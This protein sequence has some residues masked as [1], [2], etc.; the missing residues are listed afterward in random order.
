[1]MAETFSLTLRDWAS[2]PS[3]GPSIVV[4]HS[5]HCILAISNFRCLVNPQQ[6]IRS[7]YG[8]QWCTNPSK[9]S[10]GRSKNLAVGGGQH[11]AGYEC[12]TPPFEPHNCGRK[13]WTGA[14]AASSVRA[15]WAL[16]QASSVIDHA[17]V[18]P[19]RSTPK[20]WLPRREWRDRTPK[21]WLPRRE[22]RDRTGLSRS[23]FR[24]EM[25]TKHTEE[26]LL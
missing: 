2:A 23:V 20:T 4:P 5:N 26:R 11:P 8:G 18:H 19:K 13:A 17:E 14:S 16:A 25:E 3:V 24:S 9:R 7:R 10:G 15:F 6:V 12:L 1:M 21:T 22:W